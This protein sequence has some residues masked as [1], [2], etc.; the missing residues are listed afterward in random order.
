LPINGFC[1]P[2]LGLIYTIK[3]LKGPSKENF[4]NG[5]TEPVRRFSNHYG[6]GYKVCNLTRVAINFRVN[7]V[8]VPAVRNVPE[9]TVFIGPDTKIQEFVVF[10]GFLIY[11]FVHLADCKIFIKFYSSEGWGAF[12]VH[13]WGNIFF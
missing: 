9:R 7:R 6:N 3:I 4:L 8:R 11:A 12:S 1:H 5:R 13:V 10:F 2:G